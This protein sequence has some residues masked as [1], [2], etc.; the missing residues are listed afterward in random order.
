MQKA[1]LFI[2]EEL[3]TIYSEPEIRSLGY[4]IL[5]HVCKKD[6]HT[7]L[8]GKDNHLSSKE[9][10]QIQNMVEELKQYRPIQYLIETTQFYGLDFKVNEHVLIPRP[11][12][13]E[14]VELILQTPLDKCPFILDIGTGSGC[15]AITLAKHMP[16]AKIHALDLSP[17]ALQIA[18]H[19]AARHQVNIY[20][21]QEN[22]LDE[23]PQPCIN[24]CQWDIIVSNPP[25]ITPSERKQM[26][27][28][29][30]EYE[31]ATALFVPENK[32]LLFYERIADKAKYRLKKNG[33]LFF[34]INSLF[35]QLTVEMLKEKGYTSVSLLKDISGN[36]RMIKAQFG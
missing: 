25:Y 5:Q 29:V 32:P 35:G 14:L 36:D 24:Q 28:N 31:P 16:R 11:E 19:N 13:E 9:I 34:E 21:Y 17:E 26:S 30:L 15:I 27:K 23:S 2:K 4:L 20:F 12:T 10:L 6:M 7:L 8:C 1:L 3:K 22:I 33:Y 18:A